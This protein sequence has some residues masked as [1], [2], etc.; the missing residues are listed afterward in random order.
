M[1]AS[2]KPR[3]RAAT[4]NDLI[5]AVGQ[6]LAEQGAS[7]LGPSTVAQ[8]AAVDKALIYRYFGS[9]DGLIEAFTNNALYW[10][11]VEEIVPDRST[12]LAMPF[13]ERLAEVMLRYARALNAR[14]DTLAI[15]AA[16]LTQRSEFQAALEERRERFGLALL[17][18]GHDAP[19]NYDL[20]AVATLLTGA[21]HYLLIRRRQVT[22]FNGIAIATDEGWARIEAMLRQLVTPV[23][24]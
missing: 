6:V 24:R 10:P 16:E 17:T 13:Y 20:P 4:E 22:T 15:L 2:K 18:L 9:F 21:I 19:P 1:T 11:S 7:A 3:H 8:K 23:L 5:Q 14:P 12:L